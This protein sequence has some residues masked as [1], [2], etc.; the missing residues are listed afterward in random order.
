MKL[1]VATFIIYVIL[2]MWLM[3]H[4]KASLREKIVS[5]VLSTIGILLY[6]SILLNHPIDTNKMISWV[7]DKLL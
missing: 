6:A 3:F 4:L 1:L 7:I 5:L 2:S